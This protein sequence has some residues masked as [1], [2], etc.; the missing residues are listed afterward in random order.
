MHRHKISEKVIKWVES[1]LSN[2]LQKVIVDGT[3]SK[4]HHVTSGIPQ[5]SVL[6]PMLFVFYINNMPEMVESATYLFADD[7]KIFREIR[8]ENDEKMLQTDL[9]SLQSWSD[10]LHGY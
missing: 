10:T 6:G 7:T 9:D 5:G 3:E 8:D 2:R 4:C 1:F